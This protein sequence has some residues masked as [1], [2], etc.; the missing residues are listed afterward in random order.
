MA[1][2]VGELVGF[3]SL[4][5]RDLDRG[6]GHVTA[7]MQG[8]AGDV[9]RTSEQAGTG[10]G[11]GLIGRLVDQ[12]RAG[13]ASAVQSLAN[14]LAPGSTQA[15]NQAG[16]A[17]AAALQAQLDAGARQ[18]GASA[19]NALDASL[20]SGARQAGDQAGNAGGDALG[21]SLEA[22]ADQ[23]GDAA[24]EAASGGLKTKL[25]AGAAVAGV[26]AGAALFK[27]MSEAMDQEKANDV[28]AAEL[29][30]SPEMAREF[31][32]IAGHLFSRAYGE[33]ITE[34]NDALRGVW[35]QGLVD[36][37]AA[38]ADIERVTA[39]AM[40]ATTIL[41][42]D[43]GKTTS[44]AGQMIKTGIAKNA[45]EAFDILVRGAQ[46]GVNKSE[47]LLD[48]FNEYPTQFRKLGLDATTAMGL[49]SQG[50][51]NGARDS[52]LVADAL[53]EFSIRA[54]DGSKGASD[55]YK[56]LG[57]DAEAMTAKIARGGPE[58]S[59]GLQTV[60]DRLRAMK[61]PVEQNAAAVG[62]FGTQS[63]DLGKALYALDPSTA[64]A[65]MGDVAGAADRAGKTLH[66][67]ASTKIEAFKRKLTQAFVE[68]LG[69]KVLPRAE[70]FARAMK[71]K[72]GPSVRDAGRWVRDDL[73]PVLRDIAGW[74]NDHVVPAA[75]TTGRVIKDDVVPAL[76]DAKTW[77]ENNKEPLLAVAG[78]ITLFLL[79]AM[80]A[81]G[82]GATVSAATQVTAWVLTRTTATTSAITSAAAHW[83]TIAG[84]VAA[85]AAATW[86]AAV[87][88]AGWV[89]MGTQAL[90]RGAQMAA[91]WILAMGPIAWVTVAIIAIA[92]LVIYYWD[93][94]V[95]GT[96]RAWSW[97][98]GSVAAAWQWIKDTVAS[99]GRWVSDKTSD[100]ASAVTGFFG[101]MVTG[102]QDKGRALVDWL[103]GLPGDMLRALGD[104]GRLL[105]DAGTKVMQGLLDGISSKVSAVKS[106]LSN[107][108]DMIPFS[109][110]PPVKDA[111]LL[112][113]NG[114][115][116]MAGLM[117]GID[118][119]TPA[120][121]AQL[122]GLTAS[123]P[124]M[125]APP[126]RIASVGGTTP[127]AADRT[128]PMVQINGGWHSG[129]ESPDQL[130]AA[131]D[132]QMR[133]RG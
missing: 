86:N 54:I 94:I 6:A 93:E 70:D 38:G 130:A 2:N 66:D 50:L 112:T 98:T 69:D 42:E 26:A 4:D 108:T 3:A 13:A 101:S 121:R 49:L 128:G 117:R 43:I 32:G 73:M 64:V 19:G 133:G 18:A 120:L 104:L 7:V 87:I 65:A 129:G 131:L 15:G 59:A 22:E 105:W 127:V 31:G 61:D 33:N 110:G 126:P 132:W 102:A 46:Q 27:G 67:N 51:K 125:A 40:D 57:L 34:V 36:E 71:D 106:L 123:M 47:D 111:K 5:T 35:S 99:G 55:A 76:K 114:K 95:A 78:I 83:T 58:A 100:M 62:L 85:G 75:V 90:I 84:W 52:D 60:L 30:A 124:S 91:A 11:Q 72:F 96:K 16:D 21:N 82:V 116:I 25:V 24:G 1:L 48:T 14:V 23:A 39:R 118:S 107:I 80:V 37:D 88:V 56:A 41:R 28:L 109:K 74:L 89:L 29:G 77:V 81:A 12:I 113:P 122:A 10:A 119:Q 8:L 92:A 20:T 17:T 63:E 115:L 44:T 53:K 97:V 103:R 79:P 68:T 9:T 45:E